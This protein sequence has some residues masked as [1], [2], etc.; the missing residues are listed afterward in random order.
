MI[1]G[2]EEEEEEE[3]AVRSGGG[4]GG[5]SV[6]EDVRLGGPSGRPAPT[7]RSGHSG[8]GPQP[9][10]GGRKEDHYGC[11]GAAKGGGGEGGGH[12]K[13]RGGKRGR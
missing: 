7:R 6:R 9:S 13:V 2:K 4:G 8:A 12:V 11:A 10:D 1:R 3:E 5:A